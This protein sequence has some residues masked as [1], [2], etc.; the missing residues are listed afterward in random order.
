MSFNEFAEVFS[1]ASNEELV[2]AFNR[3]VGNLGWVSARGR[4]NVALHDEFIR[5]GFDCSSVV[6]GN[7][8]NFKCPIRLERDSLVRVTDSPI[9][10]NGDP[11]KN[12]IVIG[13][14]TSCNGGSCFAAL[15]HYKAIALNRLNEA[16]QSAETWGEFREKC[17]SDSF[18]EIE[19]SI[20]DNNTLIPGDEETFD[21]SLI[22]GYADGDWP[23]CPQMNASEWLPQSV[24]RLAEQYDSGLNG[25]LLEFSLEDED[26]LRSALVAEGL[27]VVR[28]D[29]LVHRACGY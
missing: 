10:T 29:E 9:D 19:G 14:T 18:R 2:L 23:E 26:R 3:Q 20:Q 25:E 8:I 21:P 27:A 28:D 15:P 7:T 24:I 17:D 12:F 16:L 13:V 6:A 11:W 5:R 22:P 4:H 1:S